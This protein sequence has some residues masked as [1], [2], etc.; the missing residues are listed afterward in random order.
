MPVLERQP[1]LP[2][3][4]FVKLVAQEDDKEQERALV[5][6]MPYGEES[7]Y[8]LKEE[9]PKRMRSNPMNS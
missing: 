9:K 6:V 5:P 2:R 3:I 7:K 8:N 4:T 1:P